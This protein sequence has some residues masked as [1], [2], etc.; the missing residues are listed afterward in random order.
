MGIYYGKK[1]VPLGDVKLKQVG[2]GW[3]ERQVSHSYCQGFQQGLLALESQISASQVQRYHS[4]SPADG[5]QHALLLPDQLQQ[6]SAP[7]KQEVPL[8]E[9]LLLHDSHL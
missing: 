1:D 2:D 6:P 3:K 7:Q 9:D 4:S 8:V 5:R